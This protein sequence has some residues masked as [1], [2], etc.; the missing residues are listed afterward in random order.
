MTN[1]LHDH[2]HEHSH[3][4]VRDWLK[5]AILFA[6]GL[7]FAALIATG[8][9]NNYINLRF[10]WLAWVAAA[11]FLLLG[12][13]SL[14]TLLRPGPNDAHGHDHSVSWGALLI[15]GAPLAL[16]LALP[17]Q[18]LGASAVGGSIST[19]TP[20]SAG[21][22]ATF[23]VAPGQRNVL[24]WLRA[25][26]ATEDVSALTGEPADVIG[27]V[28]TEPGTPEH[29]FLLAR[30]TLSC[31]VADASAIGLPVVWAAASDLEQGAWV[32]VKGTMDVLNEDGETRPVLRAQSVEVVDQPEHPYLYP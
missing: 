14:Y 3:P 6:L 8:S 27:F 29:E 4:R 28:Y 11:I 13:Y 23:T 26:G 22:A 32:Q 30:F 10:A 25:I 2:D 20:A 18:P 21:S 24:D 12:A 17:S 16:G 7:Y 19:T 15:V 5:T 1:T 9:L 31:C